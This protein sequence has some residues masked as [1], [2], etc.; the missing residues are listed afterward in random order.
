MY[1]LQN[2]RQLWIIQT[3][4]KPMF[5]INYTGVEIHKFQIQNSYIYADFVY[6]Q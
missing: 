4:V 1:Y 5:N 3:W 6:A 2:S